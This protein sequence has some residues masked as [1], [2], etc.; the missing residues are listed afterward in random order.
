MTPAETRRTS[1]NPIFRVRR[2][3]NLGLLPEPTM[4]V[5]NS[6]HPLLLEPVYWRNRL[7]EM[8]TSRQP[9]MIVPRPDLSGNGR[10]VVE[11]RLK[12][13]DGVRLWGL[14]ARPGW[15]GGVRPARIRMVGPAERPIIDT[16]AIEHGYADFVF[17][18]PAGR[19]LEDRVLD[20]IRVAQLAFGTDGVDP[21]QVSFSCPTDR[22]EPDEFLI[23][24]QLLDGRF[25]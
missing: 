19:R 14:L 8:G 15:R 18:E 10:E 5:R 6:V 12:A 7:T 1:R 20:V 21:A 11:F 24:Q 22:R 3:F 2:R 25:L 23:A 17:Q 9:V 4:Q 13:H 16:S